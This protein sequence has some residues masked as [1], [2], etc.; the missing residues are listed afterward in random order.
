MDYT[1]D[2]LAHNGCLILSFSTAGC[3][4]K[5]EIFW[6]A[7]LRRVGLL[8][9]VPGAFVLNRLSNKELQNTEGKRVRLFC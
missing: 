8:K 9:P 5:N 7:R 3:N 1:K 2:M 6:P 4:T